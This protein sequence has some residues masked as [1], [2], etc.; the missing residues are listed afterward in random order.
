MKYQKGIEVL[1]SHLLEEVQ[2]YVDGTLLYI[3]KATK[4]VGWGCLSGTRESLDERNKQIV[5]AF[6]R[7][8]TIG[9]LSEDYY[10]SE[11]TIKKIVYGRK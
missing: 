3:P 1:P 11:D 9:Q 7:G 10:L 8:Q 6:K 5:K 2:K 4:K